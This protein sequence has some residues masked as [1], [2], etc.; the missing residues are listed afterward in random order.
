MESSNVVC[1]RVLSHPVE[2][3]WKAL[4]DSDQLKKWYFDLD[5]FKLEK[6]FRFTFPG[7]GHKGAEY[8]HVCTI[9]E[10]IPR[11]KLQYS[12]EYEGYP[13]YSIVTFELFEEGA[14]TTLRL[15]HQGLDTFPRDNMDFAPESFNAG[16]D[17]IIGRILPEFLE[18][19]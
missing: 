10:I 5:D 7:R 9:T 3:V 12:W 16:W 8:I 4:T 19:N 17:E 11:K 1:E 6:G 14:K 15:T 18:T 2:K 13:G